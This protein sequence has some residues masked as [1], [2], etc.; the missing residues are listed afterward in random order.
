MSPRLH[1]SDVHKTFGPKQV[2][3]GVNL[4]IEKGQS[5]VVIG[6][7]GSGKSVMLKSVL[8]LLRPER[9][10]IKIDGQETIGLSREARRDI[11]DKIGMLFQNSAL[12]DSLP[13]WRNVAFQGLQNDGLSVDDAR[14]LAVESLALVDLGPELLD[15]FPASLSGG[16]QKRVGLARA[17]AAKPQI[18]FFDEPTTGLD[19]IM[20]DAINHLIRDCVQELGA[21]TLTITHDMTSV[22]AIADQTA[23]LYKGEI[24]WQGDTQALDASDNPFLRQFVNGLAEG[25]IEVEGQKLDAV[26]EAVQD[27]LGELS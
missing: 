22:R 6:G 14:Q 24:I 11:D 18:I 3:R 9:G 25:P 1:L 19:P 16:M 27:A 21:T 8:G 5:L 13:V 2:L 17:I 26:T 4:S 12:F 15:L 10:S 7:S 23:L 20:T